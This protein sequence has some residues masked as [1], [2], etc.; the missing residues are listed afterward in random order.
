[1]PISGFLRA[2]H[3]R[4]AAIAARLLFVGLIAALAAAATTPP[5]WAAQV[6]PGQPGTP[7]NELQSEATARDPFLQA[8]TAGLALGLT[9][10]AALAA[11]SWL[12]P[13]LRSYAAHL[14][15]RR[16]HRRVERQRRSGRRQ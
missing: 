7:E 14:K 2:Y 5:G 3:G 11:Y 15:A 12:A 10:T 6:E 16:L 8:L 9:A 4:F 1:M 13:R